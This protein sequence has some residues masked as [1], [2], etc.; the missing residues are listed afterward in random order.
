M[1]SARYREWFDA[2]RT[3]RR[4]CYIYQGKPREGCPHVLGLD[5]DGEEK[6]LVH[7]IA[8]GGS[9]PQWRCLFVAETAI[10]GPAQGRWLEGNSH[11][12]RNSCIVDV[13]IDVNRAAEQRFDWAA[14]KKQRAP[15]KASAKS[16]AKKKKP[17]TR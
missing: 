7:R 4:V 11:K 5:K 13:H 17:R 6:V 8:P 15:R 14:A 2:I 16:S 1:P 3:K 12:Q 10:A 9:Q